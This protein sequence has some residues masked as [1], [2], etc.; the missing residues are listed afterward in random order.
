[1]KKNVFKFLLVIAFVI[2]LGLVISLVTG[3][4][5]GAGIEEIKSNKAE[6]SI[7]IINDK[8]KV[9]KQADADDIFIYVNK[10]NQAITG[11]ATGD[12]S[13]YLS[14]D[15]ENVVIEDLDQ[16]NY[17]IDITTSE[18]K[19]AEVV[20]KGEN[21]INSLFG[22]ND[23]KLY[24]ASGKDILIASEEIGSPEELKITS[25][26]IK[27]GVLYGYEGMTIT[28]APQIYL[29][30]S[31]GSEFAELNVMKKLIIDFE[32]GGILQITKD[33]SSDMPAYIE[34]MELG[35]NTKITIPEN[36]YL[37]LDYKH[38]NGLNQSIIYGSDGK[39]AQEVVF[40]YIE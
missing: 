16:G 19:T 1:M 15:V 30:T 33:S 17:K 39:R 31:F 5:I 27:T 3:S 40:S 24:G 23:M 21:K 9:V 2:I 28:G 14:D 22:Y 38:S 10:N 29:E 7:C 34:E 37:K 26:I 11:T 8:G 35:D 20:F 32:E 18:K 12:I 4:K 6:D 25:G 13:V 36:G